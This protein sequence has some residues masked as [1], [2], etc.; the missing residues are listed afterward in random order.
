MIM[1]CRDLMEGL[2]DDCGIDLFEEERPLPA[3]YKGYR[4]FRV[5]CSPN[6]ETCAVV[7]ETL[8][9][10]LMQIAPFDEVKLVSV[11][12]LLEEKRD[13]IGT[14]VLITLVA[15]KIAH[16]LLAGREPAPERQHEPPP[17]IKLN[18]RMM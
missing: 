2:A 10:T 18:N 11:Q 13:S 1:N 4:W 16:A 7:R 3:D 12:T 9:G 5:A 6:N 17:I 14:L 8:G 15:A